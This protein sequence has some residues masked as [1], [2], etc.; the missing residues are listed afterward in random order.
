MNVIGAIEAGLRSIEL[1]RIRRKQPGNLDAYDRVLQ[2]L[3]FIYSVMPE[4][5]APAIPLL[6]RALSPKRPAGRLSNLSGTFQV[7][8]G[9]SGSIGKCRSFAQNHNGSDEKPPGEGR[10]LRYF[11]D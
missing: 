8:V 2:A 11:G 1:E 4:G 6:E 7:L 9:R 3:P 10:F 5:S